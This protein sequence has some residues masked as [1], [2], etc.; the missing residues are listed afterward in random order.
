MSA[1]LSG[2]SLI[3]T[4]VTTYLGCAPPSDLASSSPPP[5]PVPVH[6]TTYSASSVQQSS[7]PPPSRPSQSLCHVQGHLPISC[8]DMCHLLD[9][10]LQIISRTLCARSSSELNQAKSSTPDTPRMRRDWL[11]RQP[12]WHSLCPKKRHSCY[13]TCVCPSR[14]YAGPK[15]RCSAKGWCWSRRLQAPCHVLSQSMLIPQLPDL[16]L[17]GPPAVP[18]ESMTKSQS[19]RPHLASTPRQSEA[20]LNPLDCTPASWHWP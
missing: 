10:C 11:S 19:H 8:L 15:L 12:T 3:S 18:H 17:V 6:A 16:A 9:L 13:P 20:V 1:Q 14:L 4:Q 5:V 2:H 7:Y